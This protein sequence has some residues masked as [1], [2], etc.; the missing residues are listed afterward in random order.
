MIVAFE[1]W[2]RDAT[3]DEHAV[4]KLY[5]LYVRFHDEAESD[6]SLNEQARAAFR[7]LE[8]G[9]R[10]ETHLWD[11]FK[12]LSWSEFDRIYTTLGVE[13]EFVTGES[14]LNDRMDAVIDRLQKAGLSKRSQG[15]LVVPLDD[16]NLPPC[17][18]KK[19]DGATLYA[20]R[21]L[22]GLIYR[23]ERY[24]FHE[25]LYV[26]A[27]SQSDHFKQVFKVMEMLEE[28]E[29]VPPLQRMTGRVKHVGFGWVKFEDK[30]MSTRRG[31]IIVLEDVLRKAVALATVR[32]KEKNPDLLAKEGQITSGLGRQ[33]PT[34]LMI[35]V[36][37]VVFSQ[38]A[39]KRQTDINFDWDEVLNFEGETGPYLQYTHARLCSLRRNYAG[40]ISS[41]VDY[42]RLDREEENR[43]IELLADFPDAVRDAAQNYDPHFIAA[44]LMRLAASFNKVYQRKHAD[45]R[46]DKI[47]SDDE[48][49]TAAR[50]ALVNAVQIVVK[51]GLR[52]L[53]LQSP[54]EM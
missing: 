2:G 52:L 6:D 23:W 18:L 53:G 47:V 24:C 45:G 25:S 4:E 42:S 28:A 29:R 44:H 33:H 32:I 16:P 9:E 39:A 14:F 19:A 10:T 5:D 48:Q 41:D 46:I 15:A 49:L 7:R 1:K 40:S 17:L 12:K 11:R 38:L 37:A 51:E 27:A 43:V 3:L 31:N 34:A 20:T 13:F 36:G 35:G 21:D 26:V 50:M 54:Q 8:R 30:T 22:A